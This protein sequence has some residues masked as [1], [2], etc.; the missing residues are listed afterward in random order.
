MSI[1]NNKVIDDGMIVFDK[2]YTANELKISLGKIDE[3]VKKRLVY[4]SIRCIDDI[5]IQSKNTF[6]PIYKKNN[7]K[8]WIIALQGVRI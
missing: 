7:K 1:Y 6:L 2:N 5:I 3:L 4:Q 8:V